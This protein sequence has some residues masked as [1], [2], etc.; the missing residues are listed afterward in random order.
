MQDEGALRLYR[1]LAAIHQIVLHHPASQA[2]PAD[3]SQ[4]T[5]AQEEHAAAAELHRAV[6]RVLSEGQSGPSTTTLAAGPLLT[7]AS[8]DRLDASLG[9]V[10]EGKDEEVLHNLPCAH[11]SCWNL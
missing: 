2:A 4:L 11:F 7:N 6:Q 10:V 5:H 9:F 3:T 8:A 1:V